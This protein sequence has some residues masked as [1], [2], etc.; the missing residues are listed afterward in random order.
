MDAKF[1]TPITE[2]PSFLS[3]ISMVRDDH[4]S[5]VQK[6]RDAEQ[7]SPPVY[8]PTRDLFLATL[9]GRLPYNKAMEQAWRLTDAVEKSCATQILDA[10]KNFL[11]N[12]RPCHIAPLTGL[13]FALPNGLPLPVTPIWLRQ[14]NPNRVLVLHFWQ[15]PFSQWQLGAAAAVLRASITRQ[16]PEYSSSEIDFI[17]VPLVEATSKRRFEKLN[18]TRLKPLSDDDLA[19]FWSQFLKA[20]NE[21]H[22][23]GPREIRARRQRTLFD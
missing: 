16:I 13:S 23:R 6:L 3:T 11:E 7:K 20:W 9:S 21:Y 8:N 10:A 5:I 2:L 14:F 1:S 19:R 22:R 12:E 18:W 17:S 4:Y 15:T